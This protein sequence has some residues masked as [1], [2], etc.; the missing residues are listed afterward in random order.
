MATSIDALA[1]ITQRRSGYL[2]RKDAWYGSYTNNATPVFQNT[3][4][5]SRDGDR[6][7]F[8]FT[9][10]D[11]GKVAVWVLSIASGFVGSVDLGSPTT[12]S[13]LTPTGWSTV[14][15][16]SR[17]WTQGG[18][19]TTQLT[20]V[21]VMAATKLITQSD[22][23]GYYE[24]VNPE[25]FSGS[26]SCTAAS[27]LLIIDVKAKNNQM[28]SP[29][30]ICRTGW[31]A[32][33]S[34]ST[35]PGKVSM[36]ASSTTN[37]TG[38]LE[39]AAVVRKHQSGYGL[40]TVS[41]ASENG[42]VSKRIDSVVESSDTSDNGLAEGTLKYRFINNVSNSYYNQPTFNANGNTSACGGYAA[43]RIGG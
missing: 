5:T 33:Y 20:Y 14:F 13:M 27:D 16:A 26:S 4:S 23:G 30:V 17:D 28:Q 39:I 38:V 37:S 10:G 24:V 1:A 32:E 2:Y 41:L 7:Y 22:V 15:S 21:G 25:D 29:Q 43:I 36:N 9:S 3:F 34:G 19:S 12:N 18:D 31:N 8:N 6:M 35:T 11:V 42:F 40:P